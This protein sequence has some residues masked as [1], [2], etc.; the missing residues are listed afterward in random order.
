MDVDQLLRR[1]LATVPDVLTQVDAAHRGARDTVDAD[2]LTQCERRICELLGV[3]S[4][5]ADAQ[6]SAAITACLAFVDGYMLDVAGLDDDT[7]TAVQDHLGDQGLADFVAA[8]LVVE[9]R[10]RMAL[11]IQQVLEVAS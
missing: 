5:P 10:Y 6:D 9:Q 7:V 11:A 4:A 1:H 8:L 2:L 3:A